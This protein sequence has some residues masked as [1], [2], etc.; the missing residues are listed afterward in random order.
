MDNRIT[1]LITSAEEYIESRQ[2]AAA[3]EQISA[4]E[5]I[6]PGNK[7]IRMIRELVKS[8]QA[9]GGSPSVLNRLFSITREQ[10][11]PTRTGRTHDGRRRVRSLITS[12]EQFLSRGE[13]DNAFE[14]LMRAYLLDPV[15]PEVIECEHHVLPA[16]QQLHGKSAAQAKQE[17]K[18]NLEAR[19]QPKSYR[20]LFDRLK[21]GK[22]FR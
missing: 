18:L 12:A 15:A 5:L 3:L 8:L 10:K 21:A 22:L 13:V 20:S 1:R 16:W 11:T 7:S 2:Y 19:R 4:A 9:K 17:W 6:E 14:S